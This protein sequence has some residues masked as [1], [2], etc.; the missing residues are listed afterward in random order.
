MSTW[1]P[2]SST[3]GSGSLIVPSSVISS[4]AVSGSRFSASLEDIPI[5]AI[6]HVDVR[7]PFIHFAFQEYVG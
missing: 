1:P 3:S 7:S 4:F 5:V 6:Y 2:Y